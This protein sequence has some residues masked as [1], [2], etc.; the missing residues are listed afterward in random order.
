MSVTAW[1]A[2]ILHCRDAG[3][4]A[5]EIFADGLLVVEDGHVSHVGAFDAL[6]PAL[7]AHATLHDR[8]GMLLVPGF[9]DAH[10]HLPQLDAVAAHGAQLLD[11]LERHI[12]PAEA[13]FS[14]RGH[15]YAVAAAFCDELLRNGTTS[16]LVFGS[17]HAHSVDA[18]FEAAQARGMRIA[19]GKVL[20]DRNCPADIR[21]TAVGGI[22][23]S[24][25]LIRRWRG[26]GR[27]SYAV[28]P[29]FAITSSPEQ[30][31][32]AG[33]L[34]A[35]HPDV[36]MQTHLAENRDE[37]AAVAGMYPEAADYLDVYARAGLVGPRSVFAHC[38]HLDDGARARM[39]AAGA[40]AA[41]CP[42]SNLFLGSGLF[43][44]AATEAAGVRVG[45]GSDIGAG[46]RLSLLATM[47]EAYKVGQMLGAALDPLHA[48]YL[49]TLGG[50][51]LIGMGDRIGSFEAGKEADFVLLDPAATPLLARRTRGSDPAD[52]LFALMMLGDD[53]AVAET[54]VMGAC[55]HSRLD[56]ADA[57]AHSPA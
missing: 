35:R 28:T 46:T 49:A 16:A 3:A 20:M 25:A 4:E 2:A 18:L 9:V 5:A 17:V 32:G 41:F 14:D 57:R 21:D 39:A 33:A 37:V 52:A 34:L 19:G 22:A 48:L 36:L 47:G 53:R 29:R 26:A 44:L 31:A 50:A 42:T 6:A 43:N 38:I 54:Y 45:L 1:R 27:L 15:A 40:G 51:Q 8:R 30:L 12:F 23:D 7:P 55:R 11:W 24:E 10:V 13:A 56:P